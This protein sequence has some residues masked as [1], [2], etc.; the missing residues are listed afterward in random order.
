MAAGSRNGAS[1]LLHLLIPSWDGTHWDSILREHADADG[2]RGLAERTTASF[3]QALATQ[4]SPPGAALRWMS[5]ID[6][7]A[8]LLFAESRARDRANAAHLDD[9]EALSVLLRACERSDDSRKS[10]RERCVA[11]LRVIAGDMERPGAA[12]KARSLLERWSS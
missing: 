10:I 12:A 9:V 6:P 1:Y 3:R 7:D 11:L 2:D 4:S 5:L 8:V